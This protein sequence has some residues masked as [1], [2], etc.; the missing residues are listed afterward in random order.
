MVEK[1]DFKIEFKK[2][3]CYLSYYIFNCW[4][5]LAKFN[6]TLIEIYQMNVLKEKLQQ[7]AKDGEEFYILIGQKSNSLGR[8]FREILLLYKDFSVFLH[9]ILF[10]LLGFFTYYKDKLEEPIG[11][12]CKIDEGN[13]N[14]IPDGDNEL[15][16]ACKKVNDEMI[17]LHEEKI[18]VWNQYD[19][20]NHMV[21]S[22]SHDMKNPLAVIKGN[23]EIL[24]MM[25]E[26]EDYSRI[27][28]EIIQSTK[29][30]INRIEK[31]L[32]RI[33]YIQSMEQLKIKREYISILEFIKALK[34][35]S[36]VLNTDK[37]IHWIIPKEDVIINIDSHHIEEAFENVLNNAIAYANSNIY[38]SVE[39]KDGRLVISIQDDGKG[40]SRDALKNATSKFYSERLRSGNMG[41]GLNITK[42]ILE[43][44]SGDLIITNYNGG[45]LVKMII[46]L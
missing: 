32:D 2:E 33:K 10:S 25:N 44:H 35:N 11:C 41:L 14:N 21:S 9:S 16:Y 19:A 22:M 20:F 23:I 29:S 7:V 1:F 38:I 31:Y 17:Y 8:F 28:S 6:S 46:N 42:Y 40:F 26:G 45:A 36:E 43:K 13:L 18:K 27:R 12:I 3:F 39:I 24:E 15:V 34:H 4:H 30:N 37:R 5:F